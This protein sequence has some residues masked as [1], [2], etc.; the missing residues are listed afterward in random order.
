M[1][2]KNK[3]GYEQ[4]EA[5]MEPKEGGIILD[6]TQIEEGIYSKDIK[7]SQDPD[8]LGLNLDSFKDSSVEK[9]FKK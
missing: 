3:T 4:I 1:E 7:K 8:R 9:S 6:D 2:G 5:E